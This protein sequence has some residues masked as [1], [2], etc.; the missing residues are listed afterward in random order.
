MA[1]ETTP[2][3]RQLPKEVADKFTLAEGAQVTTY[4]HGNQEIDLSKI[5]VDQA[6]KLVASGKFPFLQRKSA[7]G[8]A[9]K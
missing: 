6:E 4:V 1:E 2:A 7:A 9:G 8:A 3:T 5:T